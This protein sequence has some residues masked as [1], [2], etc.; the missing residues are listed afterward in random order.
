MRPLFYSTRGLH[1]L[2][3]DRAQ[4]VQKESKIE[5]CPHD[6]PKWDRHTRINYIHNPGTNFIWKTRA[7]WGRSV[8][9]SVSRPRVDA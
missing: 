4:R 8:S 7:L 6:Q 1:P 5:N 9:E 3:T 2:Q